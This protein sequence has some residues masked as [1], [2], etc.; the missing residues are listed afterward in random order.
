MIV[1]KNFI[2]W[3]GMPRCWRYTATE[4]ANHSHKKRRIRT[5]S[6]INYRRRNI[7]EML[8]YLI[9]VRMQVRSSVVCCF[10]LVLAKQND[11]HI[12]LIYFNKVDWNCD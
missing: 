9:L 8:P 1:I 6:N 4:I 12:L 10:F 3:K 5:Q 11:K 7:I 2:L